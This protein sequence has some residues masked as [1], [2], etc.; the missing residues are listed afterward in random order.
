MLDKHY[1]N[2]L[3]TLQLD[4]SKGHKPFLHH[5]EGKGGTHS[6]KRLLLHARVNEILLEQQ[7]LLCSYSYGLIIKEQLI[8]NVCQQTE[9]VCKVQ[10]QDSFPVLTLVSQLPLCTLTLNHHYKVEADNH[11]N[12]LSFT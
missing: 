11:Y 6:S 5:G 9:M 4:R 2:T 12:D 7:H 1:F 8:R 10:Q 3:L